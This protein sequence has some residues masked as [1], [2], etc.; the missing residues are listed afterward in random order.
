[1]YSNEIDVYDDGANFISPEEKSS[2]TLFNLNQIFTSF[3]QYQRHRIIIKQPRFCSI[4]L[5]N[6][7]EAKRIF[8][9]ARVNVNDTTDIFTSIL[10]SMPDPLT[11]SLSNRSIVGGKE[12]KNKQNLLVI[13]FS[14]KVIHLLKR[15]YELTQPAY[16]EYIEIYQRL[17]ELNTKVENTD[18]F[19]W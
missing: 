4:F 14:I 5:S 1:M 11:F 18:G 12:N 9:Y 3:E 2:T 15:K 19:L 13:L 16:I 17:N 8:E 10:V 6:P 7:I